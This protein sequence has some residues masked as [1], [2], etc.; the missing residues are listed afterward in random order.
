MRKFAENRGNL[1]LIAQ[2]LLP[3]LV[4]F[5]CAGIVLLCGIRPFEKVQTYLRVA[6]MDSSGTSTVSGGTPGLQIV[7]TEIDTDYDGE[8]STE[9]AAVI[10]RYGSQY[11]IIEAKSI[12]LYAPVYWGGGAELL[13]RGACQTPA[14]A[15]FGSAGNSVVSAHVNTFFQRLDDLQTGEIVTV[16]TSYGKFTYEVTEEIAFDA[17]DKSYLKKTEDD[18]LTMY[19]CE[20]HLFGSSKK[21]VG[22]VC[23]L[24]D[25]AYYIDADTQMTQQTTEGGTTVS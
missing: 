17:S 12:E 25:R 6:F 15:A 19:T 14:S 21:R 24:T 16:Y 4:T 22:V 7:E 5:L 9:G 3:V 1:P 18:R 2:I 20:M 13:E 10:P 8:T 11:A 23:K